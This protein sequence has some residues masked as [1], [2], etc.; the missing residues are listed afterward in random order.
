[1]YVTIR[2]RKSRG[3]GQ[4]KTWKLLAKLRCCPSRATA[5]MRASSGLPQAA[6]AADW[7]H[8]RWC[9]RW[10]ASVPGCEPDR[11][12][13]LLRPVTALYFAAVYATFV[14]NIEPSERPFHAADVPACLARA[15]ELEDLYAGVGGQHLI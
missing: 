10:R 6:T 11:A 12:V 5:I 1:M 3:R 13:A 9:Q 4:S 14:A 8:K 2:S 15:V 7:L